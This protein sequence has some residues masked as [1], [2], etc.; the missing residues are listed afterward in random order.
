MKVIGKIKKMFLTLFVRQE[1]HAVEQSEKKD[2]LPQEKC[3]RDIRPRLS[4]SESR[5]IDAAFREVNPE[6][7]EG[8]EWN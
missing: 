6:L 8:K 4:L 3:L 2:A 7:V 5:A 1:I